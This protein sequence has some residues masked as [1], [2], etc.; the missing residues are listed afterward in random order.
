MKRLREKKY[1][2]ITKYQKNLSFLK[3][4]VIYFLE[5]IINWYISNQQNYV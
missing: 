3:A 5:K 1:E 2:L 4:E